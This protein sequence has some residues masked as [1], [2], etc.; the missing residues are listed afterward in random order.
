MSQLTTSYQESLLN[1][2]KDPTEAAEYLTAAFEDG[3]RAALL[4]A[5]Q[6]V[7]AVHGFRPLPT[8]L[9]P[10]DQL[11]AL[12]ARLDLHVAITVKAAS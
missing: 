8:E 5:L 12:L 9:P 2:L 7:A 3:D 6:N 4:L 10:L 11:A 1:A